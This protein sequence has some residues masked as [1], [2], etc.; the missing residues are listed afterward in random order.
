MPLHTALFRPRLFNGRYYHSTGRGNLPL[1]ALDTR[2]HHLENGRLD[3]QTNLDDRGVCH[4]R[5]GF[6]GG[7]YDRHRSCLLDR[8]DLV[9]NQNLSRYYAGL[10]GVYHDC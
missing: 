10:K 2:L 8:I 1:L 7:H 9:G 5:L 3:I 6:S 4:S